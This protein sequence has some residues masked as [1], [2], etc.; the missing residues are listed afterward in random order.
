MIFKDPEW[1]L[2]LLGALS[3]RLCPYRCWS[4]R[5]SAAVQE[6]KE[7]DNTVWVFAQRCLPDPPPLYSNPV[8]G[9]P[10]PCHSQGLGVRCLACQCSE[11][12]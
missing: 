4:I 9:A 6:Q 3:C 2:R 8:L 7:L 12:V 10:A 11:L 1:F 5:I